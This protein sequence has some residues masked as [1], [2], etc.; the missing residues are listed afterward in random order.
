LDRFY[1]LFVDSSPNPGQEGTLGHPAGKA[2]N[3]GP[4]PNQPASLGQLTEDLADET[5]VSSRNLEDR[6]RQTRD[7]QAPT[8][9]RF[10]QPEQLE[11]PRNILHTER[12]NVESL[13][14]MQLRNLERIT[15]V[16]PE[17]VVVGENDRELAGFQEEL[18]LEETVKLRQQVE[19]FLTGSQVT[20]SDEQEH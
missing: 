11:A 15:L 7:I 13:K 17:R 8:R 1:V 3:P 14:G 5:D 16:S 20:S 4:L 9:A 10:A 19:F 18:A 12:M 6:L 2:L